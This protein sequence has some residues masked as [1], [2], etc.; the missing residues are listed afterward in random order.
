MQIALMPGE[1]R[2]ALASI[3]RRHEHKEIEPMKKFTVILLSLLI[4]VA[5]IVPSYGQTRRSRFGRKA[6]TAAIV[7]GGAGAARLSAARKARRLAPVAP[8]STHLIGARREDTSNI[9]RALPG[10]LR[11][12]PLSCWRGAAA[13]HGKGA[14]HRA[15]S[16]APA[17]RISIHAAGEHGVV[18][19]RD[20]NRN[21]K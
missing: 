21:R 11:V 3:L 20:P 13:G 5:T 6:R 10:Q 17:A 8:A 14:A 15:S 19:K 12:A 7:A 2:R 9:A 18:T 1:F 4:L 16:V